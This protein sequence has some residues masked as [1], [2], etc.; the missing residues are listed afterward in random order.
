MD[1][2]DTTSTSETLTASPSDCHRRARDAL[3]S[4]DP[5]W[6][7]LVP[8]AEVGRGEGGG[9]LDRWPPGRQQGLHG[10]APARDVPARSTRTPLRVS[11]EVGAHLISG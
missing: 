4:I 11:V 2:R 5:P 7:V 8:A 9:V 3:A 1:N 10:S 6:H